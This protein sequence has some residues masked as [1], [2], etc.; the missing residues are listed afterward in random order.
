M[1][2]WSASQDIYYIK[3]YSFYYTAVTNR[4]A[5]LDSIK[6]LRLLVVSG[7]YKNDVSETTCTMLKASTGH[8]VY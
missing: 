4:N 6:F 2:K 3:P 5:I 1:Q 8:L 7:Y